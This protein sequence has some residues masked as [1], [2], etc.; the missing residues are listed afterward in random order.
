MSNLTEY[1]QFCF[2]HSQFC[3]KEEQD[4][5]NLFLLQY[6]CSSWSDYALSKLFKYLL[7]ILLAGTVE[8]A[9]WCCWPWVL[10]RNAR[11]RNL[12]WPGYMWSYDEKHSS[13]VLTWAK[14]E[15]GEILSDQSAGHVKLEHLYS[16]LIIV[17]QTDHIMIKHL[18]LY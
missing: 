9:D 10:T 5:L 2:Q 7:T 6:L 3:D 14:R 17:S 15:V 11:G 13:L 1:F 8:Y 4:F 16:K 18:T 12:V